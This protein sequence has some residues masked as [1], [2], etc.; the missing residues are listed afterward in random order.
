M[1]TQIM[2]LILQLE[3]LVAELKKNAEAFYNKG[4]K[5]AGTRVRKN[6]FD[7]KNLASD[8]RKNVSET[9]NAAK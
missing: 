4:N 6:A 5:Q 9:K 1:P 3:A 8:I 2:D 7:I